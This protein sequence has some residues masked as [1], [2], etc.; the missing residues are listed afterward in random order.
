MYELK[1]LD[2][3]I[4][5]YISWVTVTPT[6]DGDVIDD[7]GTHVQVLQTWIHPDYRLH[8]VFDVLIRAIANHRTTAN[9]THVYWMREKDGR[10]S[11]LIN[12]DQFKRYVHRN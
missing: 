8:N 12:I 11:G 6:A 2:G 9:A 7:Q 5:G 1:K 3:Y 4:Y 10:M